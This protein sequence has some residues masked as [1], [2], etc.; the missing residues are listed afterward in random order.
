MVRSL[1]KDA[2]NVKIDLEKL[3]ANVIFFTETQLFSEQSKSD[4]VNFVSMS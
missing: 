3:S 2:C 1:A 4:I